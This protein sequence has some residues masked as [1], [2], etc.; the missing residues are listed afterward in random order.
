M[1]PIDQ[2]NVFTRQTAT[3]RASAWLTGG[4]LV[5][6]CDES[7]YVGQVIYDGRTVTIDG[8]LRVA[9]LVGGEATATYRARRRRTVPLRLVREIVWLDDRESAAA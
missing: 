9:S 2:A 7:T 3:R 1:S 8:R 4:A 5:R 6:L